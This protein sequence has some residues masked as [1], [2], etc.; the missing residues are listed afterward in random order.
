M[1]IQKVNTVVMNAGAP[2]HAADSTSL[3]FSVK[4]GSTP[5][6]REAA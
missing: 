6:G 3:P 5:I 4:F 2:A 1:G